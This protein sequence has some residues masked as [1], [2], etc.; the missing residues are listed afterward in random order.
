[1]SK[2]RPR[3]YQ[4][5]NP[6]SVTPPPSEEDAPLTATPSFKPTME[7]DQRAR[8]FMELL[9][10]PAYAQLVEFANV[11]LNYW[12][13]LDDMADRPALE[14][15]ARELKALTPLTLLPRDQHHSFLAGYMLGVTDALDIPTRWSTLYADAK[16]AAAQKRPVPEI[17]P[18]REG[19]RFDATPPAQRPVS[20]GVQEDLDGE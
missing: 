11:K 9:Q 20:A 7:N 13:R 14:A 5:V 6:G 12:T 10:H 18:V 4:S 16:R 19:L 2:K 15:Y 1:M 17:V 8:L 3:P